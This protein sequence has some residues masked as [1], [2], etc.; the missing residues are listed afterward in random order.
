MNLK[1]RKIIHIKTFTQTSC[2]EM[3]DM[4]WHITEIRGDPQINCV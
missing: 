1:P 4:K 2:V 3:H